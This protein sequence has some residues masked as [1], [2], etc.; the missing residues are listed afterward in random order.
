MSRLV[1][2]PTKWVCAQRR[3]RS[4]WASAQSD[5]SSLCAQWVAKDPSFLHA[6]SKDWLDWA[7]AQADLSLRWA[8]NHIV[9]FVMRRLICCGTQGDSNENPQDTI[10]WRIEENHFINH[11]I[12]RKNNLT[13][14]INIAIRWVRKRSY[15]KQW[16]MPLWITTTTVRKS[17]LFDIIRQI[18]YKYF[19][20]CDNYHSVLV[21]FKGKFC[22]KLFR[23]PWKHHK[24]APLLAN[25]LKRI[26]L[27]NNKI[28]V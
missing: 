21:D 19:N 3:L 15:L 17:N 20:G 9:G 16:C 28:W 7:D 11:Q 1:T 13:R 25:A 10:L 22:F 5:Q 26:K 23:L 14:A 4:A 2:K 24:Q 27:F 6:D 12:P 8:H 18:K